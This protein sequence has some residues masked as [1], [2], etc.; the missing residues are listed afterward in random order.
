MEKKKTEKE[1]LTKIKELCS[2]DDEIV[3]FC[4]KKIS[5]LEKKNSKSKDNAENEN[6]KVMLVE[7]L[8]KLENAVTISDLMNSSEK[9][10]DTILENGKRL[11]NQKINALFIQLVEEGK[12]ER[13]QDK[14]SYIYKV[15]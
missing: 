13:K 7:E 4:D 12:I 10:R 5:Q 11:S 9:V 3:K 8:S 14:K 15:V 6:L 1:L 2:N